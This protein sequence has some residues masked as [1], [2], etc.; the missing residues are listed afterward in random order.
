[1]TKDDFMGYP[2]G[3]SEKG[4]LNS[5]RDDVGKYE[6]YL[7]EGREEIPP[8]ELPTENVGE[9]V[10]YRPYSSLRTFTQEIQSGWGGV[11]IAQPISNAVMR[12]IM[13]AGDTVIWVGE[14]RESVEN[15]LTSFVLPSKTSVDL[16]H[17]GAIWC[18]SNGSN[19]LVSVV[20]VCNE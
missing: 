19:S 8:D 1:M 13:N 11:Q 4:M 15:R 2:P 7:D 14:S 18:A 10:E 16:L 6:Q 17:N 5:T 20:T 3:G 9:I 12:T